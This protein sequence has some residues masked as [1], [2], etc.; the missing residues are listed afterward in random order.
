MVTLRFLRALGAISHLHISLFIKTLLMQTYLLQ[1]LFC[2]N[3]LSTLQ[4]LYS[5]F[6]AHLV[7][8]P[9]S[10]LC[11]CCGLRL[12]LTAGNLRVLLLHAKAKLIISFFQPSP[13]SGDQSLSFCTRN[14]VRRATCHRAGLVALEER[15]IAS[16]GTCHS[17]LH[18]SPSS[19]RAFSLAFPVFN[20][21]L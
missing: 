12:P 15:L 2:L 10:Q 19:Y 13:L 17:V 7:S 18:T 20:A 3:R 21:K 8:S 14:R 9:A 1:N 16:F 11:L 6:E 4:A 5:L